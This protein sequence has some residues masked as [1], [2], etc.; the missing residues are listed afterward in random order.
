MEEGELKEYAEESLKEGYSKEELTDV[1]VEEGY[2]E[3]KVEGILTQIDDSKFAQEVGTSITEIELDDSEYTVEQKLVRNNYKVFNSNGE[4]VLKA[5]QKLFRAKDSFSFKDA[6][7]E[8]V[9]NVDAEQ[10]L[11]FSG[12]YTLTDAENDE[13]FAVLEKEFTLF[14][15]RWKVKTPEGEHV[16]DIT[17]RSSALDFLRTFSEVAA[18]IPHKYT[19]ETPDGERLGVIEGEFSIKDRYTVSI[20]KSENIPRE[21]LIAAAIS[22]D[23]LEGS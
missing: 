16:A 15:H 6:D 7:G 10:V 12:D 19:I 13:A 17:S 9:F 8:P 5:S 3:E 21:A 14:Q 1:L 4:L 22:A 23:A 18:L 2:D 20:E 11:D